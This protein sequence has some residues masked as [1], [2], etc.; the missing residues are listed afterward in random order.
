[1][2]LDS[3]LRLGQSFTTSKK[4]FCLFN[5]L[6]LNN[7]VFLRKLPKWFEKSLRKTKSILQKEKKK[8]KK[9]LE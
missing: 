3:H 9:F 5:P 1:M 6:W 7:T 8:G 2:T 4:L